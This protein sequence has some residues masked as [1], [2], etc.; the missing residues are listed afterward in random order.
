MNSQLKIFKLGNKTQV[1]NVK[2]NIVNIQVPDNVATKY[3]RN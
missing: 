1:Y 2:L 3:P